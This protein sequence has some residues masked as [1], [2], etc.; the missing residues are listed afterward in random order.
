M[1]AQ[2]TYTGISKDQAAVN[3]RGAARVR[4]AMRPARSLE[5]IAEALTDACQVRDAYHDVVSA[6][7]LAAQGQEQ[8]GS[9]ATALH[10][11][12]Q[13]VAAAH[14]LKAAQ[15][16]VNALLAEAQAAAEGIR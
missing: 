11:G 15:G 1:S 3:S 7:I 9:Q 4:A 13:V 14:G 2:E 6:R 12:A 5:Q 16:T 10:A 8:A